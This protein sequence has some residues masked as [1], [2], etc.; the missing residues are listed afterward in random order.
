M[1]LTGCSR[2]TT[3]AQVDGVLLFH[4]YP[5]Q[6]EITAQPL[7]SAGQPQGRPSI[8]YADEAG[9]FRLTY[10][11]DQPGALVGP[12]ALTISVMPLPQDTPTDAPAKRPRPV[13]IARL[14]QTVNAGTNRWKLWLTH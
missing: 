4:G 12:H 9:Y 5:T 2:G 7:D 1:L 8:G 11:A 13:K 10:A 6:A 3:L 14:Q